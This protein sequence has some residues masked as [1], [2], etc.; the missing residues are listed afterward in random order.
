MF[1]CEQQYLSKIAYFYT[2]ERTRDRER[3]RNDGKKVEGSCGD[4]PA[5]G[6]G[7]RFNGGGT[8]WE[9][10]DEEGVAVSITVRSTRLT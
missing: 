8:G 7:S 9:K 2:S 3:E 4:V 10:E 1:S 6:R 5:Q